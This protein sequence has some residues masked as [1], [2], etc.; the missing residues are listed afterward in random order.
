MI[1]TDQLGLEQ[2]SLFLALE[3][4][5]MIFMLLEHFM[6]LHFSVLVLVTSITFFTKTF[7]IFS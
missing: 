7:F 1:L 4:L 6:L 5:K 2:V 3:P